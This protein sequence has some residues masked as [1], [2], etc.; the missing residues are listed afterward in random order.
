MNDLRFQPLELDARQVAILAQSVWTKYH[1]EI[2]WFARLLVLLQTSLDEHSSAI[3]EPIDARRKL[4]VFAILLEN[5]VCSSASLRQTLQHWLTGRFSAQ[6]MEQPAHR[7]WRLQLTALLTA[8]NC[9]DITFILEGIC[10]P[11]LRDDLQQ[12]S[13]AGCPNVWLHIHFGV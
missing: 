5:L 3:S 12:V 2:D 9:C 4:L 7:R 8:H 11:V 6:E 10:L 1:N 13:T